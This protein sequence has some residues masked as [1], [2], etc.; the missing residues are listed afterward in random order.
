MTGTR[1]VRALIGAVAVAAVVALGGLVG[2]A[3][4]HAADQVVVTPHTS[5][6]SGGTDSVVLG[7][8]GNV[9]F[10]EF[11]AG[12][13]GRIAPDGTV[14]E[15]SAG[16]PADGHPDGLVVGPDGNLWFTISASTVD[17]I[18][19]CNPTGHDSIGRITPTGTISTFATP[20][21]QAKPSGITVGP[22]GALWFAESGYL[23]GVS[24]IGGNGVGR[25][26]TSGTIT[27]YTAGFSTSAGPSSITVGPDGRLWLTELYNTAIAA[28]TTSGT[29]TE[30]PLPSGQFGADITSG[31]DGN[32]W[33]TM[34]RSVAAVG[35]MT[36]SGVVSSFTAGLA[37]QS[38]PQ[39]ITVGPDGDLWVVDSATPVLYRVGLDG[40]IAQV[41]VGVAG[42]SLWQI[43][44]GAGRS[45]WVTGS[46]G[47]GG[48]LLE[49]QLVPS[50]STTT[51][52]PVTTTTSVGPVGPVAPAFTG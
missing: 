38:A 34:G 25:I 49:V 8:D 12:R 22:D 24:T 10:T 45:L 17:P 41:P 39:G 51:T 42:A 3:P 5:G 14:T 2:A 36:P 30:Y 32:L 46:T 37:G 35:R 9:W 19:P 13:I 28:V 1:W 27:E 52:V 40:T 33:F 16:M 23:C 48:L 44:P 7:P 20:T 43:G 6:L 4:S 15:F 47:Q 21:A 11:V 18:G 50:P 26:T 31:P 29:V